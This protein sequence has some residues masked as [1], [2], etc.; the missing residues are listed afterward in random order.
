MGNSRVRKGGLAGG[1]DPAVVAWQRAGA[2]NE[3]ALT[4]RQK[5]DRARVRVRLDVPEAVAEGL[6]GEAASLETSQSQLGAFLLAWGLYRLHSGDRELAEVLRA[7]RT[8]SRAINV[9]YDFPVPEEI[10]GK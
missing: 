9:K 8:W 2:T 7:S 4:R 6:E 1:L 5:Y 10:L 3:A